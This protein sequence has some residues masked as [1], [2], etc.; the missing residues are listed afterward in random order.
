MFPKDFRFLM[1]KRMARGEAARRVSVHRQSVSAGR[2]NWK[3]ECAPVC[4]KPRLSAEDLERIER[5]KRGLKGFARTRACG[6]RREWLF[7]PVGMG[8]A[9][10]PGHVWRLLRQP[11]RSCQRCTGRALERDTRGQVV[12]EMTA[13]VWD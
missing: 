13:V 4:N 10:H 7:D 6:P 8:I 12:V 5:V 2:N 9:S 11:T 3:S 1:G